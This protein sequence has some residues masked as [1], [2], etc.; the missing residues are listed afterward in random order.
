[1]SSK[2]EK[3]DGAQ[4]ELAAGCSLEAL[5]KRSQLDFEIDFFERILSRDPNYAEVLSNLGDLFASKGCHR[6]ALQV[7]VRLAQLRPRNATVFYNLACSH[8]VLNHAKKALAALDQA[9]D[10]GY[11]DL[12]YLLSDPDL[13]S[14]R[15]RAEFR[16]ILAKLEAACGVSRLV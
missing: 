11:C 14:V 10:L 9:V 12:D 13:A 1:M 2:P 8:A 16:R 4:T 15:C 6:R 7:D 5:R 3:C